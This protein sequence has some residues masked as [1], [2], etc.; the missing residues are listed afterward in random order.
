MTFRRPYYWCKKN[1]GTAAMLV[2]YRKNPVGLKSFF[3]QKNF[4]FFFKK[5]TQLLT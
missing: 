5:F 3:M 1:D 2:V 4:L